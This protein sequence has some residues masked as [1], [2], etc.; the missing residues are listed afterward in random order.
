MPVEAGGKFLLPLV[1]FALRFRQR[2]HITVSIL[3][4]TCDVIVSMLSSGQAMRREYIALLVLIRVRHRLRD[5]CLQ[6]NNS[7]PRATHFVGAPSGSRGLF[8]SRS[9]G[10][11]ADRLSVCF[12]THHPIAA[13]LKHSCADCIIAIDDF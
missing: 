9:I 12:Y 3:H 1:F 4:K 6:S 11:H 7:R 13:S 10:I 5:V 8:F 2:C